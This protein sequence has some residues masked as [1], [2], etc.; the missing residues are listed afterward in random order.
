MSSC[1]VI[2]PG[3]SPASDRG[4][5]PVRDPPSPNTVLKGRPTARPVL[6]GCPMAR[7]VLRERPKAWFTSR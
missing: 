1:A 7:S 2:P 5:N 6:R 4:Y 3:Q